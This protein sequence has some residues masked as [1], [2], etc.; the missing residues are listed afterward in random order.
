MVSLGSGF[1]AVPEEWLIAFCDA[2]NR[3][4]YTI[5]WKLK[6][7][8]PCEPGDHIHIKAWVPQNDI[9]AHPKL[10]LFITHYGYNSILESVSHGKPMIGFPTSL[11]QPYNAQIVKDK[12][13]G[14]S[15]DIT[16]FTSDELVAE[17]NRVT[18]DKSYTENALLGS[19]LLKNKPIS[20]G[21]RA[22]FWVQHIVDF[23]SGHLTS[24]A[25]EL[26]NMQ[27][28]MLDIYLFIMLVIIAIIIAISLACICTVRLCRI[29]C[30]KNNTGNLKTE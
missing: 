12:G 8:P 20:P 26:S 19:K 21:K 5:I 4:K 2:F 25:T 17:I 27:Y 6:F 3:V 30:C 1:D 15:L 13:M 7:Q 10:I 14:E 28:I 16:S 29:Y 18:S 23:G 22:S 11:D 24:K 9:L